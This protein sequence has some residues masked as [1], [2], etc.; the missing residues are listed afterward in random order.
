M[1]SGLACLVA[2]VGLA[3][4][5]ARLITGPVDRLAHAAT[6]IQQFDL[7]LPAGRTSVFEELNRAELAFIAMLRGLEVFG[8]YVPKALVRRL[9][10]LETDSGNIVPENRQVTVLFTDIAGYTTIASEME[11][12]DLADMLNEYFSVLAQP[13]LDQ[14]GTLNQFIG[15]AL[16]A[17]WNAPA[18][19]DDHPDRAIMAA[20]EIRRVSAAFNEQREAEGLPPL[21]TRIGVHT[22]TVLVGEIG[23]AERLNYTIVGDAVNTAARVEALGK[24]V[25]CHLCVSAETRAASAGDYHWREIGAVRLRG[26][27]EDTLVYTI[28]ANE[29]PA[30]AGDTA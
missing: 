19:Q 6:A 21:I 3:L 7:Q 28:D 4:L 15:D 11:P 23:A 16:M 2:A 14:E 13:V 9:V 8:R 22:G 10:K 5:V 29:G 26:R 18:S 25:G 27:Q 30:D 24:D 12:V 17:F 20:L 1:G